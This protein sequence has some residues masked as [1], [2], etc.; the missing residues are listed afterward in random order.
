MKNT[1]MAAIAAMGLSATSAYAGDLSFNAETEYAFEAET[2][3]IETG[4][5]YNVN[6]FTFAGLVAFDDSADSLDFTG[7]EVS[8]SYAVTEGVDAYVRIEGD[9]D[10]DHSETVVGVSFSF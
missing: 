9:A 1:F 2:F 10:W 5:A 7:A 3:S 6:S 4:A 8:V